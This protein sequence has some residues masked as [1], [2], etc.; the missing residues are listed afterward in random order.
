MNGNN[1]LLDTNTAL[2]LLKGDEV[3]KQYLQDKIFYVSCTN[4]M[5]LLGFREIDNSEELA[6]QFFWKNVRLLTSIKVLKISR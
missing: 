2:Y 4:E 6:I 3:L 5:E 1:L